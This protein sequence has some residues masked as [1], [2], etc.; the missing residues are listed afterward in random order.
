MTTISKVQIKGFKSIL[1]EEVALGRLNVFIGTNGAGKSNFLEAL[2]LMSSAVEGS[3][4]YERLG[5]RGAR[6]SSPEIF[7]SAF[8]NKRRNPTFNIKIDVDSLQYSASINA[9][10]GF[11]FNAESLKY[12]KK[13]IAGRSNNGT[14]LNGESVGSGLDNFVSVASAYMLF[15]TDKK[16]SDILNAVQDFAIFAPSTPI[17]RGVAT[18]SSNKSPLGLYGGRLAEALSEVINDNDNK[19]WLQKFFHLFDWFQQIG[20]T[21]NIDPDLVSE[22]VSL[23]RSVVRYKDKYMKT[24]FNDLYAYD[25]SEGALY[26]LFVLVLLIHKDSPDIFALDNIDSALNPGMVKELVCQISN[27]LDEKKE[28]QVFITTHNPSTLDAIDLFNPDHRLFVVSRNA[29]GHTNIERIEPPKDCT[30]EQWEEQNY[31]LKLSDLWLSGAIGGIPK[32]F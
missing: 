9:S 14:T 6:L 28:K 23:G 12:K 8:R 4:D 15:G 22:H 20:V 16:I 18:D 31:G 3:V 29:E 32:G 2:A 24:S 13:T 1:N 10:Q 11:K 19:A 30:K 17:L 27:I 7:R 5:R 26:I 25:V 21:S